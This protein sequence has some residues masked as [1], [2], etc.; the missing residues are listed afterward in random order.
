M[1]KI[2]ALLLILSS[3][4]IN[5]SIPV[6]GS[7]KA[8]KSCPAYTSKN[9]KSNPDNLSIQANQIY[10]IRE[11]NRNSADWL[12]LELPDGGTNLRWVSASCGIIE[13]LDQ[14]GSP[15]T[16]NPGLAD[17][18]VFA[19][20]SQPG[21]CQTYG[22]EAGKPECLKLTPDSYAANHLTL[23]GLWPNQEACGQRYGFCGVKPKAN[24]CDYSPIELSFPVSTNLKKI[25]P[26]Y[27][28]GS[29]LERHEW[30][31]HGSCQLLSSDDYFTLSM[32]LTAE[33]DQSAFGHYLTANSGKKVKLSALRETLN[34]SFGAHNGSKIYLACK[35]GILVDMFI[36]LPPLI[37]FNEALTSLVN[38]APQ[39]NYSDS[40][41]A[42]VTISDFTRD[43]WY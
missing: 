2:I 13:Y 38:K 5:A 4:T 41:P 36:V 28:Y 31:K 27:R 43:S 12:R 15:C 16:N 6:T 23:H 11:M 17:S 30:N 33:V 25:M 40:C 24:H 29:C 37:P 39:A 32:R 21:F 19:V 8:L 1:I 42:T 26:S 3:S 18:Y 9:N 14:N 22:Y 10:K 34:Q 35:N 20:S 7:F